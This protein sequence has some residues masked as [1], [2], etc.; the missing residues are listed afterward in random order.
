ML[1]TTQNI[2]DTE[3]SKTLKTFLHPPVLEEFVEMRTII[4]A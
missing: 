1:E 2:G 3:M 4:E